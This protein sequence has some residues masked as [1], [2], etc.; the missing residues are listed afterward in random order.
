MLGTRTEKDIQSDT[1][2][3]NLEPDKI[4]N[5]IP[6]L[7]SARNLFRFTYKAVE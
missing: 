3:R 7:N 2:A 4:Y 6:E 1:R 5:Q